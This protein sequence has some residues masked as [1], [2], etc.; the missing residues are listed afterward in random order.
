MHKSQV[1]GRM[2]VASSSFIF[3]GSG[4]ICFMTSGGSFTLQREV[5]IRWYINGSGPPIVDHIKYRGKVQDC[6]VI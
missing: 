2:E 3:T 6:V 4:G 1:I 5:S